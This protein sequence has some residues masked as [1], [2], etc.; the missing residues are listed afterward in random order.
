[1]LP[2]PMLQL[3]YVKLYDNTEIYLVEEE[4]ARALA[5]QS[6]LGPYVDETLEELKETDQ[7]Q[8]N[9]LNDHEHRITQLEAKCK[10]RDDT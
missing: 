2:F 6:Q 3:D 7:R 4:S 1:M 9:Q 8:Y 5:L 10:E